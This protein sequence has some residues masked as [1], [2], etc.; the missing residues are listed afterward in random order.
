MTEVS[1]LLIA[2][3]EAKIAHKNARAERTRA[4]ER[5]RRTWADRCEAEVALRKVVGVRGE[6]A[7][8]ALVKLAEEM[9]VKEDGDV[10][11]A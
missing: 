3:L 10:S 9:A 7:D 8:A 2:Y 4:E 6:D 5:E 11:G 1:D